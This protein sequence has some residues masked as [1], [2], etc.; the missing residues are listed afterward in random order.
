MQLH[1]AAIDA[2]GQ[3]SLDD[4]RCGGTR[5]IQTGLEASVFEPQPR[6]LDPAREAG[7]VFAVEGLNGLDVDAELLK[8]APGVSAPLEMAP[9]AGIGDFEIRILG[10]QASD[11]LASLGGEI[12]R[13]RCRGVQM[14]VQLLV[15]ND[16]MHV[17]LPAV[18]PSA[19]PGKV[20]LRRFLAGTTVV[21]YGQNAGKDGLS[22]LNRQDLHEQ[23]KEPGLL[24]P[25]PRAAAWAAPSHR[26]SAWEP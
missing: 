21:P 9:G 7:L 6:Q 15:G 16:F 11:Q 26:L 13:T 10:V 25:G 23:D 18:V 12:I 24:G 1:A 14:T 22:P 5:G 19:P 20:Y 2:R 3:G 4:R 17:M 8:E